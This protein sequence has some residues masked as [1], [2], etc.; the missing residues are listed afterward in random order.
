VILHVIVNNFF[1]S[2]Y[3]HALLATLLGTKRLSVIERARAHLILS[4]QRGS[5]ILFCN[6]VCCC[7][8]NV[9][10]TCGDILQ[11]KLLHMIAGLR[12]SW[13]AQSMHV[14][15]AKVSSNDCAPGQYSPSG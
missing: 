11:P 8:L 13:E 6:Q 5:N 14:I 3:D 15:V 2:V 12:M 4:K 1:A 9:F 10:V 7:I